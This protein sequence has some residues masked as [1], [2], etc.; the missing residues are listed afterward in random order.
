M[1]GVVTP[2]G[3]D[4]GGSYTAM[5]NQGAAT[6]G[7]G[8]GSDG[9]GYADGRIRDVK[10]FDYEL[11]ADQVSSLYSGS[12]NV[13]PLHWWKMDEGVW[14]GSNNVL[15]S[16]TGTTTNGNAVGATFQNWTLDLDGNLTISANG[17]LSAPRGDIDLAGN[18]TQTSGGTYTHNNGRFHAS[19]GSQTVGSGGGAIGPFYNITTSTGEVEIRKNMTVENNLTIASGFIRPTVANATWTMG[20]ATSAASI[21]GTPATP[22]KVYDNPTGSAAFTV[23]GVNS[24][25]PCVITGNNWDWAYAG[26]ANTTQFANVD[27]QISTV[28]IGDGSGNGTIK[29]T[30]D[31]EFDAVTIAASNTLDL[32]GQ[33]M[34]TSGSV[35]VVG[36]GKIDFGTNGLL[37]CGDN[38]ENTSN[39]WVL[40]FGTNSWLVM[41]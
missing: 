19:A 39:N 4:D 35:Y 33:R 23:Q 28:T 18:F 20:T 34:E 29:L 40:D 22:I 17:T 36:T 1:D 26:Q 31:C 5:H 30:G 27:C 16:G 3:T 2:S 25:Y 10:I 6:I 9:T 21:T 24:L 12:Y 38:F 15:D 11:S 41:K 8:V 37:F 7:R 13:T 14:T 32:N